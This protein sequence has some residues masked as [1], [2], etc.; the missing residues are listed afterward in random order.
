MT[1]T[2][3]GRDAAWLVVGALLVLSITEAFPRESDADKW[4]RLAAARERR[5]VV[6]RRYEACVNQC[7]E[8]CK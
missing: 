3:I 2:R 8:A 4:E 7:R 5:H 6:E 1:E